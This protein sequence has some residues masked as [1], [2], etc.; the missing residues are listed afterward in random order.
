MLGLY[1]AICSVV[2]ACIAECLTPSITLVDSHALGSS[3]R[4][5]GCLVENGA[6]AAIKDDRGVSYI[7]LYTNC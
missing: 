1:L 6:N 7:V 5:C 4:P 3:K 2:S